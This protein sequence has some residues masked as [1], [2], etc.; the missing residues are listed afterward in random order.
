VRDLQ[1]QPGV[2]RHIVNSGLSAHP[3]QNPS[4]TEMGPLAD[5]AGLTT[6]IVVIAALALP[7]LLLGISLRHVPPTR[8]S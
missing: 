7:G 6:L 8:E 3:R 1:A 4:A 5:S 2:Q